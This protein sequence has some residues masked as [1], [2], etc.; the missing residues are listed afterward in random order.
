MKNPSQQKVER[1]KHQLLHQ[2]YMKQNPLLFRE[3]KQRHKTKAPRELPCYTPSADYAIAKARDLQSL[4]SYLSDNGHSNFL[5]LTSDDLMTV[6]DSGS[7]CCMSPHLDDFKTS[8]Y[9]VK[10]GNIGGI[11]SGL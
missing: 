2:I 9:K 3:R 10:E 11:A 5:P 1:Q 7:T 6:L 8:T 4:I